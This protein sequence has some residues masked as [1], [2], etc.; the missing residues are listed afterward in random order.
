M[1]DV[2]QMASDRTALRRKVRLPCQVV[3]EHDFSLLASECVDLSP[4]GMGVRALLPSFAGASVLV[5][6]RVPGSSL[7][8][9]V[10]ARVTRMAWGRRRDDRWATLGLSFVNLSAVDRIILSS[11]LRGLPPPAPRRR[12]RA[13]YARSVWTVS[14][15][16]A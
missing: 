14:S 16:A 15:H 6:F 8:I 3:D 9:D 4:T 11:R 5:S 2:L 10:D 12:L 13:D 7:Y 1:Q